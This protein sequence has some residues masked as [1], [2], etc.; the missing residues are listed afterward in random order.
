MLKNKLGG[1]NNTGHFKWRN[2][3]VEKFANLQKLLDG[4][5]EK[6]ILCLSGG[7]AAGVGPA[8]R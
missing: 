6:T 1:K 7:T 2:G 8:C 4:N 3:V 5:Q